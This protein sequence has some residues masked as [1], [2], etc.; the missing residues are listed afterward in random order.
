ML[1]F[2][3]CHNSIEIDPE[4]VSGV[5]NWEIP[6]TMQDIKCF[7][8]FA[9]FPR[10]FNEGYC[11]IC[12]PFFNLLRTVDKV[13][14]TSILTTKPAELVKKK[15]NKTPIEWA[16]RCQQVFDELKSRFCSAPVLTSAKNLL[17]CNE[18]LLLCRTSLLCALY[19]T[20][21]I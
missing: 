12:T 5:N 1:G 8:D 3:I 14:N 15:T 19:S 6:K 16:P 11:R 13:N 4:K 17:C 10:M 18:P 20:P 9:H 2:V 7:L 21:T